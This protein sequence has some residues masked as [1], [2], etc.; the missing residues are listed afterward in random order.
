MT[1][2]GATAAGASIVLSTTLRVC[3][4]LNS[5]AAC[6]SWAEFGEQAGVDLVDRLNRR[7]LVPRRG[8]NQSVGQEPTCDVF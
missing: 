6:G 2:T 7:A 8:H 3:H 5:W 1:M 4:G